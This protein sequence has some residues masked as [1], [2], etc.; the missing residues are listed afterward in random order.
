MAWWEYL[1]P[2]YNVARAQYGAVTGNW[3]VGKADED[4]TAA[5]GPTGPPTPEQG[6]G[7]YLDPNNQLLANWWE[8]QYGPDYNNFGSQ[9]DY[10]TNQHGYDRTRYQGEADRAYGVGG[11]GSLPSGMQYSPEEQA[12]ILRE[13]ERRQALTTPEEYGGMYRTGEEQGSISGDPFA[14][15]NEFQGGMA[16]LNRDL[17]F[18]EGRTFG[19]LA[20]QDR[21]VRGI[22][23]RYRQT[24]DTRLSSGA[25]AIRGA[26]ATGRQ[27]YGSAIDQGSAGFADA[28]DR[29]ERG[30][31]AAI[32]AGATGIREA[33]QDPRMQLDA[34]YSGRM[35]GILDQGE[36]AVRGIYQDPSLDAS[37]E[38]MDEYQFTD[39]D[40]GDMEALAGAA[41]GA[42]YR[43]LQN[44]IERRAAAGGQTSA[45]AMNTIKSRNQRQ[46]AQ[47]AADAVLDA[48]VRGTG[49]QLDA[50][51]GRE[52]MRLS[53]EQ[54]NANRGVGA[55][56]ELGGRRAQA[57]TMTEQMRMDAAQRAA[58][59]RAAGETN[60]MGART[61]A[62]SDLM[63]A[64]MSGA[65]RTMTAR[66][67][68]ARD[69]MSATQAGESDIMHTGL[70]TAASTA[71]FDRDN[72][73]GLSQ[74]RLSQY[75]RLTGNR[76]DV[77]RF[78]TEGAAGYKASGETAASGR[79]LNAADQRT[80]T[81][82]YTAG[83]RSNQEMGLADR[84]STGSQQIADTRLTGGKEQRGYLAGSADRA[85]QAELTSS[86][87]RQ[88]QFNTRFGAANAAGSA[89][90]QLD[91]ER[92]KAAAAPAAW[93]RLTGAA[94]GAAA[95]YFAGRN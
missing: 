27:D 33:T 14:G 70:D 48:R 77:G 2:G 36:G 26:V 6:P 90:A 3:G 69:L 68:A 30:Y 17:D 32:D 52:D 57:E 89:G 23:D 84:L 5:A 49:M 93:E 45:S 31:G 19:Q 39:A 41:S 16:G 46:M 7:A 64:R 40:R 10:R 88:A 18:D 47:E 63:G 79:A 15:Y 9:I 67:G 95:G 76:L 80:D 56:L 59:L 34:G 85:S 42:R 82:R 94:L 65:D 81:A 92:K 37:Q 51:R 53:A 28:V 55:E 73:M 74:S 83:Q 44:E 25:G 21:N 91:I 62:E 8:A 11:D 72:E 38:F 58:S 71:G 24:A 43:D 66:T 78:G 86:G 75:N 60:I 13:Q 29:G 61:G 35:S 50:V 22:G 4:P 1:I 54:A 20:E 87:Q 12:Q